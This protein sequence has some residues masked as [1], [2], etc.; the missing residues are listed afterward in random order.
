[1]NPNTIR[2]KMEIPGFPE[3]KRQQ[4][5]KSCICLFPERLIDQGIPAGVIQ[6]GNEAVVSAVM[7]LLSAGIPTEAFSNGYNFMVA[8]RDQ[9]PLRKLMELDLI[10]PLMDPE[11]PVMRYLDVLSMIP[12][13][14]VTQP[15]KEE[16][17]RVRS[18]EEIRSS[19]EEEVPNASIEFK[20]AIALLVWCAEKD[21]MDKVRDYED[22]QDPLPGAGEGNL[23]IAKKYLNE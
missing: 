14:V 1:M 6:N 5:I 13:E 2:E 4:K 9:E 11:V 19:V 3:A 7:R 16:Q 20:E 21:Q 23:S 15:K 8:L 18:L 10:T 12:F 22:Y 17:E